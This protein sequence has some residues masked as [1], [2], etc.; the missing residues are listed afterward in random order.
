MINSKKGYAKDYFSFETLQ[1]SI[2]TLRYSLQNT[3]QVYFAKD[4]EIIYY[5]NDKQI[6]NN[7]FDFSD[8]KLQKDAYGNYMQNYVQDKFEIEY[9][10]FDI[11]QK[12]KNVSQQYGFE[13]VVFIT[14]SHISD[15]ELISQNQNLSDKFDTIRDKLQ[16]IFGTIRDFSQDKYFNSKNQNYYDVYHY[17][18]VLGDEI[19]KSIETNGDFGT[20]L[21]NKG[22][23]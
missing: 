10:V 9:A 19:V 20:I 11:L 23:N 14:P 17:R 13:L 21:Y 3:P 1:L 6:L 4:G 12:V 5:A 7:T 15:I 8:S 22:H 2:K 16:H 18:S